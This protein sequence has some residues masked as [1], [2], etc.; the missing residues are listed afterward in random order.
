MMV[1]ALSAGPMLDAEKMVSSLVVKS[2]VW[3]LWALTMTDAET[4][5]SL[6]VVVQLVWKLGSRLSAWKLLGSLIVL[7]RP[8]NAHF[9]QYRRQTKGETPEPRTTTS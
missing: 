8:S 4:L 2:L 6:L 7:S 5:V 3:M 1:E 9:L